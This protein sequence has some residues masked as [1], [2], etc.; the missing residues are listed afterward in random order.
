MKIW[1]TSLLTVVAMGMAAP[2]LAQCGGGAGDAQKVSD[3]SGCTKTC[4]GAKAE[5][6]ADKGEC[7]KSCE[8]TKVA[9]KGDCAKS[10]DG[11]KA[12]LVAD[13]GD[14]DKSKCASACEKPCTGSKL[15]AA[16]IPMLT[17]RVGDESTQCPKHAADLIAKNPEAKVTYVLADQ[18]FSNQM[19]AMKA[20]DTMLNDRLNQAVTVRYAIGDKTVCCPTAAK[21]AAVENGGKI[22][23]RVAFVD[24]A[25]EANAKK[26]AEA[27][28][29]A[30]AGVVMK[31]VVDGQEN[32]C[33]DAFRASCATVKKA[34][35]EGDCAKTCDGAKAEKV[36]DK[37]D[38]A[39]TCDGAK[40]EKVADKGDCAK[41]CDGA[42]AE[43]VADK[44]DCAK[45]C[46]G[47]KAEK[48]ADKGDCAKTCDGSKASKVEYLVAGNR[49]PCE[50][51]ARVQLA[52]A[53]LVAA[54]DAATK[55]AQAD[56]PT[57]KPMAA[58]N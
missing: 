53:R 29:A 57:D 5:K 10:C 1:L 19:E 2:A 36:A 3:K 41:T 35:T 13:K 40:A 24:F 47:A 43:K 56:Q 37:G 34:S 23:Y 44:G 4:D 17:T 30:A 54:W 9:D 32:D 58:M 26:A 15:K 25:D 18:E 12:A 11:T 8:G 45:T 20:Y 46:D 55:I 50:M 28:R 31:R 22:M 6:V 27:A 49:T 42:K 51:S 7:A 14:C 16:G 39:K 52:Q 21:T 33:E 38:C 48:V